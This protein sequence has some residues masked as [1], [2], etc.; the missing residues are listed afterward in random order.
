MDGE[1][2]ENRDDYLEEQDEETTIIESEVSD[3]AWSVEKE[4]ENVSIML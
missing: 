1:S 3:D 2:N 4:K